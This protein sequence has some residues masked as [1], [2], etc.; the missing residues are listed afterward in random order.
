MTHDELIHSAPGEPASPARRRLLKGLAASAGAGLLATAG[1]RAR[2]RSLENATAG[3]APDDPGD[4]AFWGQ[5]KAEFALKP[6]LLMFNAANLC[7]SPRLVTDTVVRLT[8]DLDADPSFQNREKFAATREASRAAL[9]GFLGADGREIALTRN[10]SEGNNTVVTGLDLGPGDEVLLWDQNHESNGTAWAVQAERLGFAL[11]WVTTPAAPSRPADLIAPFAAALSGKTRL[12]AFSH[13]SNLSGVALPAA[14]L[15]ALAREADA[16]SLIDGAQTL[17]ILPVNLHA[18]GCDFYA[19]SNHKW[20]M[21]PRETGVLYVRAD[22]IGGLWPTRVTHGWEQEKSDGARRFESLGQRDDARV[23]AVAD[24]IAFH[25]T[26]GKARIEQRIRTLAARLKKTLGGAIPGVE[27][28]TPLAPELSAGIVIV[29]VHGVGAE[30]A[31]ARLYADHGVACAVFGDD[32][33]ANIRLC[34]HVYT[35]AADVDRVTGAIAG[36]V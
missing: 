15:C 7:P 27:F 19:A 10:T 22:R 29:T 1:A 24:A 8:R 18:L 28:V 9:A 21:G 25:H 14:E 2:T 17:G 23:A 33:T 34:P 4:E 5:V 12:L 3:L 30:A 31:A 16:L 6:G 20:L 11:R 32:T 26:V 13:V 36:L 35:T